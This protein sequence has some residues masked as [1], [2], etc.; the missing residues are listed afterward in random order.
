MKHDH[1]DLLVELLQEEI[2]RLKKEKFS[3]WQER[4]KLRKENRRLQREIADFTTET[5]GSIEENS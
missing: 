5:R 1:Y 2:S 3:Y 4:E